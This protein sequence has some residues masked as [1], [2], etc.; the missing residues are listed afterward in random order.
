MGEKQP[1]EKHRT[2]P[3]SAACED[4]KDLRTESPL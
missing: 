1:V 2:R 3:G 4:G